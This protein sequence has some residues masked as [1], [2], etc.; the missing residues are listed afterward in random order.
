[1]LLDLVDEEAVWA[2]FA[3][4]YLGFFSLF[5]NFRT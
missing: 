1:M 3:G 2:R 4:F 5:L